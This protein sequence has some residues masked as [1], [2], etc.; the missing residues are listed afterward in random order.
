MCFSCRSPSPVRRKRKRSRS[1]SLDRERIREIEERRV[2]YIGKLNSRTTKED[3]RHRFETF[4]IITS[5]SVHHRIK[6]DS[7]GFVTY[8]Y[9]QDA[10][11]AVEHGNDDPNYP[12]VDLSF[13]GRRVF[14]KTNYSDLGKMRKSE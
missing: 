1:R 5:V 7:Y 3:L 6:N 13:G 14:C 9:R 11:D 10:Y 4:G 2:I 12:K 8:K